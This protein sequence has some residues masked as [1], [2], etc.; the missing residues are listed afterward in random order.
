MSFAESITNIQLKLKQ[1]NKRAYKSKI[2]FIDITKSKNDLFNYKNICCVIDKNDR[3]M[4]KYFYQIANFF[5]YSNQ[6]NY[7]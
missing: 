2:K 3:A 4:L 5:N 6:I 1:I 7:F